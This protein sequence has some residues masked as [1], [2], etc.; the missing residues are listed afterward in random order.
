MWNCALQLYRSS[1]AIHEEWGPDLEG[2]AARPGLAIIAENELTERAW[3]ERSAKRA[4][5]QV[6]F[7]EGLG[8]WWLLEDPSRAAEV[9]QH[10]AASVGQDERTS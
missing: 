2:A 1:T 10:F 5:A 3:T 7:L 8:H 9:L 4:G 6:A